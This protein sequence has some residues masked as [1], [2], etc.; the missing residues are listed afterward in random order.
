M[1]PSIAEDL[2]FIEY[3]CITG[4]NNVRSPPKKKL[5]SGRPRGMEWEMLGKGK[6]HLAMNMLQKQKTP[7]LFG[8]P[9][10]PGDCPDEDALNME[11]SSTIRDKWED[12]MLQ[13]CRIVMPLFT[14]WRENVPSPVPS[15]RQGLAQ[16]LVTWDNS[17]STCLN[18]FRG[19]ALKRL[20][21][22]TTSLRKCNAWT[23]FRFRNT[24]FW[25]ER[26]QE[27]ERPVPESIDIGTTL[28]EQDRLKAAFLLAMRSESNTWRDHLEV[29]KLYNSKHQYSLLKTDKFF[30]Q[31]CTDAS[32]VLYLL[33][34]YADR[35]HKCLLNFQYIGRSTDSGAF[36]VQLSHHLQCSTISVQPYNCSRCP[37][38]VNG[39]FEQ[40]QSSWCLGGCSCVNTISK[41]I[42]ELGKS[43]PFF[44]T[45]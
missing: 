11:V 38:R 19:I 13:W 27:A 7:V 32:Y 22:H 18:K 4:V 44:S 9:N 33:L 23:E 36:F 25:D 14:S 16:V 8:I 12:D 28:Q 3:A 40:K 1:R 6:G 20:I 2:L 41:W 43:D 26:V 45:I 35:N 17:T 24:D 42:L 10:F 31:A 29:C 39:Y 15:N 34:F 5:S 30:L 21:K 37:K